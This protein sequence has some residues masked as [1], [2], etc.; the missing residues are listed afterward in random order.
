MTPASPVS[1]GLLELF[2]GFAGLS[3]DS[4]TGHPESPARLSSLLGGFQERVKAGGARFLEAPRE[5]DLSLYRAVHGEDYVSFLDRLPPG[6]A[7]VALDGDT[8]VSHAT[9]LALREIAGLVRLL[10]DL[11]TGEKRRVFCAVRPPGHHAHTRQGMGF[12][13]VNH[14]GLLCALRLRAF[15]GE[16]VMILDF[17]VH[18]GNGTAE[19][20]QRLLP[21]ERVLFVSTHRFP[22]YPGTGSGSE[23]TELPEGGGIL[24]IP[25]PEG[26]GDRAYGRVLEEQILPRWDRFSPDT[27]LVS[28][29]FD[30]H[31]ADPLGDMAL[32][33]ESFRTIGQALKGRERGLTACFLE[34]GYDL[35]ALSESVDAFLTGWTGERDQGAWIGPDL[36]AE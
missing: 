21:A 4:G 3:H 22:F 1:A 32:S 6:G 29:G 25:L 31:G 11:P 8:R 34:G 5:S 13:A 15:P 19:I 28:A 7:P 16:K 23:N 24:D 20:V 9:V 17:D 14:V 30:G 27:V 26:T 12:C 33:G 2:F 10:S 36:M 18:H 35:A